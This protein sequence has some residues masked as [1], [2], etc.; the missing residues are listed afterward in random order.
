MQSLTRR[1]FV[2]LSTAAAAA[3]GS[4]V[5]APRAFANPMGL[6]LG[7][8]LY[9]VR[10]VIGKD[11]PGTLKALYDMGFREVEPAGSAG[12]TM[13]ELAKMIHDAGLVAP[14]AHVQLADL[15]NLSQAFDDCHSLGAH[16][17]TSSALTL[18][19]AARPAPPPPG[20]APPPF[21]APQ[22][23]LDMDHWQ[24]LAEKMNKIGTAA[25][26]A[27]LQYAYHSHNHEMTPVPDGSRGIDV[28][29][30]NTDKGLV[31]F[32]IDC[33]WMVVGGADPV[34]YLQTYP[35]RVKMLHVKDFKPIEHPLL[36]RGANGE[37]AIG[38]ELGHGFIKYQPIFDAGKK[39]GIEHAF[40]EQEAPYT[41]DQMG[42]AAEDARAMK[43]FH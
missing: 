5:F 21:Q 9:T 15:D 17:A 43:A 32:E 33:G 41:P 25:K 19:V 14:S 27:G 28:L 4:S 37:H 26:A 40:S 7:I 23:T 8:Q 12:H 38:T 18:G 30:K 3:A 13:A 6:P 22:E 31:S 20:E 24:K 29:M 2:K 1:D 10:Q 11:T 42:A 34:H 16:Y 36:T 35:G 39:A